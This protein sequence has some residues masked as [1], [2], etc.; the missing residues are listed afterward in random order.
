MNIWGSEQRA[1]ALLPERV[2]P[3]AGEADEEAVLLLVLRD[4]LDDVGDRLRHR[5]ALDRRLAT[6]LLG[7]GALLLQIR[8]NHVHQRGI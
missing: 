4:V 6:Q 3:L 1:G 7:D 5:H 8:H 2:D